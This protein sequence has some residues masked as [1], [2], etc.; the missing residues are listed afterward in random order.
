MMF[1]NEQIVT[2][3][4]HNFIPCEDVLI[5]LNHIV[6]LWEGVDV[7]SFYK[8]SNMVMF[9]HRFCWNNQTE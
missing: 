3:I 6:T 5:N 4:F 7:N 8:T 9:G 2:I 1:H